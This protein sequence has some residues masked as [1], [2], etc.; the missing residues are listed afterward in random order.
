MQFF[1]VNFSSFSFFTGLM[2]SYLNDKKKEEERLSRLAQDL[3]HD[4][5]LLSEEVIHPQF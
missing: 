3:S 2:W 5:G 4:S 1:L